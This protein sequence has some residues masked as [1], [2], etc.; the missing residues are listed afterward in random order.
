[1]HVSINQRLTIPETKEQD[2][3]WLNDAISASKEE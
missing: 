1:M 2:L 3:V